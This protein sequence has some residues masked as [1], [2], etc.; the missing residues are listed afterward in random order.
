MTSKKSE[1]LKMLIAIDHGNSEIKTV[2]EV[3]PSGFTRNPAIAKMAADWLTFNGETF[4]LSGK[5]LP[6]RRDKTQNDDYYILTLFAIGKELAKKNV[7]SASV[8]LAVGLPPA[9]MK[10]LKDAFTDYLVKDGQPVSF[11]YNGKDYDVRVTKAHVFPQAYPAVYNRYA[12]VAAMNK[13]Y[14]VD[15]GGY[16]TDV[17]L[18]RHGKLDLDCCY[19]LES[20]V[21]KLFSQAEAVL[22]SEFGGHVDEDDITEVINGGET[23]LEDNMKAAILKAAALHTEAMLN[24][25]QAIDIDLG[26]TPSYF[27]GGGGLLLK[28]LLEKSGKLKKPVFLTDTLANAKGYEAIIKKMIENGQVI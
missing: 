21:I 18:L 7:T 9:H 16:T 1:E 10:E 12:E 17:L 2:S 14:I 8:Q 20:G 4:T 28:P 15:I 6:Y 22:M 25:F 13:A 19:S 23:L 5:H 26:H 3:F 27:V 24:D 11:C